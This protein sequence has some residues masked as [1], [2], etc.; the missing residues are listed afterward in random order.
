MKKLF[1]FAIV[2]MSFSMVS[3]AQDINLGVKGGINFA[4]INGSD[5]DYDGRTGY[6]VGLV[7]EVSLAGT[8]AVQPEIIYSAQGAK[9]GDI[10][11]NVD[12]L[13]IPILAKLKF[14]DI[15]SVEA[16]PQFGFVINDDLSEAFGEIIEAETFDLSGAVGASA[17]FTKFFAQ[18]RYNFGL[19]EIVKDSDLKNGNFQI[20]VGYYFL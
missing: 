14:A 7:G 18:I 2:V 4:N 1:I 3:N 5:L 6:H 13:N 16:G 8:F 11:L 12:Y 20:S 10:D 15:V 9:L 19:T 17:K